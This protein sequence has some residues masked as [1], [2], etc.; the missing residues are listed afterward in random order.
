MDELKE[1]ERRLKAIEDWKAE[2]ARSLQ[3]LQEWQNNVN[4]QWLQEW[5]HNVN[6]RL[7]DQARENCRTR[8]LFKQIGVKLT[9]TEEGNEK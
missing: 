2:T 7:N 3:W 4:L 8:E 6:G 5:Q 1:L 9:E